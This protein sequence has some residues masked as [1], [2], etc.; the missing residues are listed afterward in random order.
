MVIHC[1]CGCSLAVPGFF[2]LPCTLGGAV[3]GLAGCG[4]LVECMHA[5]IS[6]SLVY[7]L[8]AFRG[9]YWVPLD[10]PKDENVTGS[11]KCLT[12]RA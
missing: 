8:A 11:R 5:V 10:P 7:V 12:A 6:C 2:S 9:E 3:L 1:S 4:L